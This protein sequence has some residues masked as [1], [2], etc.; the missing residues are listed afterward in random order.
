MVLDEARLGLKDF[1][2]V[3]RVDTR[4][5]IDKS[6]CETTRK[7]R[8][9][10]ESHFGRKTWNAELAWVEQVYLRLDEAMPELEKMELAGI[11][12]YFVQIEMNLSRRPK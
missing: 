10:L 2:I 1:K 11:K 9:H 4:P 12:G 5:L 6:L 8:S 7:L 3:P